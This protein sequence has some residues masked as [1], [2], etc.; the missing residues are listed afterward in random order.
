MEEED[1]GLKSEEARL[2][3]DSEEQARFK[4]EEGDQISDESRLKAEDN[5]RARMKVEEGVLL[6]LEVIRQA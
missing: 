6:V 2:K 4:A 1:S 3:S 5:K